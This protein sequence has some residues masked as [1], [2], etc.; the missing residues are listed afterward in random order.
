MGED[1]G[2]SE[3]YGQGGAGETGRRKQKREGVTGRGEGDK[4]ESEYN[5]VRGGGS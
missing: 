2:E 4:E 5:L 3:E 1:D